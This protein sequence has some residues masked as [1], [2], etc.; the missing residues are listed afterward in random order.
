MH[1]IETKGLTKVFRDFW[2]R[3]K[4]RALE[5]LDLAVPKGEVFGLLGPNGSGK[6]TTIKLLL[7][8]LHPTGGSIAV[9]GAPAGAIRAKRAIG[10]LPEEAYLYR[11]LTARE[12]VTLHGRLTGLGGRHLRQRVDELLA[13]TGLTPAADRAVGEFSKGMGRRVGLAQ[14]RVGDPALL[15]LDEPTAG[16]DPVGCREVKDLITEL[17]SRGKTVLLT[18]HLL[19]DVEDV[20]DRLMILHR[21]RMLAEGDI[22][23]LL[24]REDEIRLAL[25]HLTDTQLEAACRAVEAACGHAPR[26]EHPDMGL[27]AFFLSV[28]EKAERA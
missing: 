14:A 16:L 2:R 7:G 9:L 27:E 10:Y 20:C 1:A 8:L 28:I 22:R 4:V 18:S 11:H 6:S 17:A 24:R 15:I 5:G 13:L 23:S 19:A 12:T 21:G 25:P 26:V 3:P